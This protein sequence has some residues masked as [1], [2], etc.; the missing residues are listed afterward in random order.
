MKSLRLHVALSACLFVLLA[1]FAYSVPVTLV[2]PT[3]E[4]AAA[5]NYYLRSFTSHAWGFEGTLACASATKNSAPATVPPGL[6]LICPLKLAIYYQTD[7]RL[8]FKIYDPSNKRFEVPGVIEEDIETFRKDVL[9]FVPGY[10]VR[11]TVAPFAITVTNSATN[12]VLFDSSPAEDRTSDLVFTDRYIEFGT[13]ISEDSNIYGLGERVFEFRRTPNTYTIFN[14]DQAG[15]PEFINLYGSQPFY[16]DHRPSSPSTHGVLFLNGN[17]MDVVLSEKSVTYKTVGGIVDFTIVTGAK[18]EDVIKQYHE[19]IGRPYFIP[20]WVLGFHQCRWGYKTLDE[21]K[22]V[23]KGYD[24]AQIPLDTMWLD[25]EYMDAKKLWF[26]D[27]VNYPEAEVKVFVD[28]LHAS[29]RHMVPIIDPG[30]FAGEGYEPYTEG[31]REGIFIKHPTKDVPYLGNVWPGPTHFPDWTNP[32]ATI[33]WEK[34]MNIFY[35]K[36]NYDGLWNDMNELVNFCHGRCNLELSDPST[37]QNCPVCKTETIYPEDSPPYIPG[38]LTLDWRSLT[39]AA[40]YVDGLEYDYHNINAFLQARVTHFALR[41]ILA[42]SRPFVLTR[43][44]FPGSGKYTSKWL[45]DNAST[46]KDMANSIAGIMEY[47]MYGMPVVGADICGFIGDT[48]EELCLRWTELG[49]FYPFARNHNAFDSISQEPYLWESV[50]NASRTYLAERYQLLPHYYT[51]LYLVSQNGGTLARPLFFEF[52][53]D[54]N[55][56]S[57]S[58]QFLIGSSLLVTPVLEP[59]TTTVDGYFPAARWYDYFTGALFQDF[60]E[61]RGSFLTLD[62]PLD[63]INVHLRGGIVVPIQLPALTT[64][65]TRKNSYGAVISFDNT[66]TAYGQLFIDDGITQDTLQNEQ[67]TL[68]NFAAVNTSQRGTLTAE[69]QKDGFSGSAALTFSYFRVFGA[70]SISSVSVNGQAA[71]FNYDSATRTVT[72]AT[73]VRFST[74]LTVAW[75]Y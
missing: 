11:L 23:V 8:R 10:S 13:L 65:E 28:D 22:A 70:T 50:T 21:V 74:G 38:N 35:K 66:D 4:A 1:T 57:I 7:S 39:M 67:Y 72:L 24:D 60:T 58:K 33:Y 54:A 15:S 71:Q 17:A 63:K 68:I 16:L 48:T 61:T 51:Q 44:N 18:P 49:A 12:Q 20:Y 32:N 9:G 52:P 75:E 25:I 37:W 26:Y 55:T 36:A 3:S 29:G 69:T 43:A 30:V 53:S 47:N 62:A 40:R 64:A 41:K 59:N 6:E 73:P 2:N 45:G 5:G 14:R 31:V 56:V 34:W 27:P 42:P 19:A 46:Y